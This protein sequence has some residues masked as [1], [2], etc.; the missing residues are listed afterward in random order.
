[1]KRIVPLDEAKFP[2]RE[3]TQKPTPDTTGSE[4]NAANLGHSGNG[5]MANEAAFTGDCISSTRLRSDFS[6][7]EVDPSNAAFRCR[8]GRLEVQQ[9]GVDSNHLRAQ[10]RC[11]LYIDELIRS[12]RPGMS[13][14][15]LSVKDCRTGDAK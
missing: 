3:D 6:S 8:W 9:V 12:G 11:P 5:R 14:K 13:E 10:P 1:M 4:G 7:D 2:A 15:R